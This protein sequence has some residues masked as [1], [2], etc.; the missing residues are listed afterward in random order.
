MGLGGIFLILKKVGLQNELRRVY[1]Y[2]IAVLNLLAVF[3]FLRFALKGNLNALAT[4]LF[5]AMMA[6]FLMIAWVRRS[7]SQNINVL[8]S[9]NY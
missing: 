1:G 2:S 4:L 6:A 5:Y 3:F 9:L 8:K 7:K